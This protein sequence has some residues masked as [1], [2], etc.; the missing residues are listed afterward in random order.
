M[1]KKLTKKQQVER[2]KEALESFGANIEEN[3]KSGQR[4][5]WVED[6]G[7]WG[8]AEHEPKGMYMSDDGLIEL[9]EQY[10]KAELADI[11]EMV[12]A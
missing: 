5:W 7:I 2:A 9:A 6:N 8:L 3:A 10:A 1:A 12:Q 11:D 4:K